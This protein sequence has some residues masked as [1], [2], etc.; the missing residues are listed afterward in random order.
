MK[1]QINRDIINN[2]PLAGSDPQLEDA[3]YLQVDKL[4]AL[5]AVQIALAAGD[6]TPS[7][8]TR[9]HYSLV[10]EEQTLELRYL[11]DRLFA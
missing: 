8:A 10:M 2:L 11:L 3:L 9:N 7:P 1:Q 5:C 4:L 6:H